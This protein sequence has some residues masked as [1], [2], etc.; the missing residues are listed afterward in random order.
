MIHMTYTSMCCGV[1]PV[2]ANEH[3]PSAMFFPVSYYC[4]LCLNLHSSIHTPNSTCF[5]PSRL[6]LE[7][8]ALPQFHCFS[9][10]WR[11]NDIQYNK[12]SIFVEHIIFDMIRNTNIDSSVYDSCKRGNCQVILFYIYKSTTCTS[13]VLAFLTKSSSSVRN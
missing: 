3:N 4:W 8:V 13:K 6:S 11:S 2:T 12:L 1:Y 7:T 9:L 10:F 5:I